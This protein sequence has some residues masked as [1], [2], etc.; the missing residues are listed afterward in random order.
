MQK[1]LLFIPL[2]PST[3]SL[4]LLLNRSKHL[5]SFSVFLRLKVTEYDEYG[6]GQQRNVSAIRS[7]VKTA[8]CRKIQDESYSSYQNTRFVTRTTRWSNRELTF[9]RTFCPFRFPCSNVFVSYTCQGVFR[10]NL[11]QSGLHVCSTIRLTYVQT[12]QA[13]NRR[14]QQTVLGRPDWVWIRHIGYPGSIPQ[15]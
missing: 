12:C 13:I 15:H 2:Y 4:E 3:A 8:I 5:Y 6:F 7:H 10:N 11:P 14:I 9:S 1:K